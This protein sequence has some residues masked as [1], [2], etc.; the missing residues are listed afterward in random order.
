MERRGI[1]VA[2]A[3]V[4][5]LGCAGIV[6]DR[7]VENNT[8]VFPADPEVRIQ[9]DPSIRY[10]GR[11]SRSGLRRAVSG[12][13]GLPAA[14]SSY[15]FLER[16]KDDAIMRGVIIRV[17]GTGRGAEKGGLFADVRN[18]PASDFLEMGG[19]RYEHF[20]AVRSGIFTDGEMDLISGRSA[21]I[22][23]PAAAGNG[24]IRDG[25][26][27]PKCFMTEAFGI[28]A[29]PRSDTRLYVFYFEDLDLVE[30]GTSCDD[31]IRGKV[32][33]DDEEVIETMFMASRESAL[34][35][36]PKRG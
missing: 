32:A 6:H 29:G 30:G 25:G 33:P 15:L 23:G 14:G 12:P 35:F 11:T 28:M 5:L 13:G 27:I 16:D 26:M 24:T 2:L 7:S 36:H 19:R 17:D 21:S 4:M 31:W 34:S 8:F 18:K 9:V 20:F 3:I 10:V 22:T 1:G